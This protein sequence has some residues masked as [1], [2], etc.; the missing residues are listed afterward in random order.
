MTD[1]KVDELM[2]VIREDYEVHAKR[3]QAVIRDLMVAMGGVS[4][5]AQIEW[6]KDLA[7]L[8]VLDAMFTLMVDYSRCTLNLD[9]EDMKVLG[10]IFQLMTSEYPNLAKSKEQ[11]AAL[12]PFLS[13]SKARE[14]LTRTTSAVN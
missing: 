10:E 8:V 12:T 9:N 4:R 6:G 1:I 11:W 2:H 3:M 13:L 14:Y 7:Q 5:L